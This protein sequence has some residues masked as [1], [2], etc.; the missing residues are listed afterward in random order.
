MWD[1]KGKKEPRRLIT[2]KVTGRFAF[3]PDSRTLAC[4][5]SWGSEIFLWDTATGRR[6][7]EQP[8]HGIAV[9]ALAVSPDGQLAAS[10]ARDVLYL[11]KT[12]TGEHDS[13]RTDFIGLDR[14][15]GRERRPPG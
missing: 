12:A 1:L 13:P 3:T 5:S 6:V 7:L 8:G 11:C 9:Q 15:E 2:A 14:R 10:I 4:A